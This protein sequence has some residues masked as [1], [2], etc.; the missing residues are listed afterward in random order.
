VIN[1]IHIFSIALLLLGPAP[2]G[3]APQGAGTLSWPPPP[4]PARITH[5]RTVGSPSDFEE[6]KGFL[7]N[8][9]GFFFGGGSSDHWLV[10][11]VGIAVAPGEVLYVADPGAHGVHIIDLVNRQ[12]EF[13]GE[14]KYGKFI[15]PVGCAVARDGR[16]F[17]TDSQRGDIV[18]MD[19]DGDAVARIG[20]G[21]VRPTGI[22]IAGDTL[23]VT[24]TGVHRVVEMD[25]GGNVIRAF[26]DHGAGGGEFNFPI[27]IAV[28][29]SLFVVD[30]LNYRVQ[31][32]DR[33]GSFGSSI[34][35]IGNV[36]GRFA[37]PKA[38]AFDS[39]RN[40]YVTDALMDNVQIF[41]HA[42]SLLLVF[43]RQG[44]RDGEFLSPSGIDIDRDDHIYVVDALNRRIQV[45]EYHHQGE[46][47]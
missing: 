20:G 10:Q 18:V 15:S 29:E 33:R 27:G 16:V 3:P 19:P 13:L 24:D 9:L 45:F 25:L 12:Y 30:A 23:Y 31:V 1:P 8:L 34:G 38:I 43:G 2:E 4:Q 35:E 28:S 32:L 47:K 22:R 5:L 36:A 39:D 6:K 11:P 14:T 7:G 37:G 40:I 41:D 17:V 21:L 42:G 46:G 44:S 26:G